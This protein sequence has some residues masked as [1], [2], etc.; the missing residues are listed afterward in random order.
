MAIGAMQAL[1]THGI[2]IP[3]DVI[4][5]GFDGIEETQAISPSLT[6]VRAPWHE[7]GSQGV[8]LVLLRLSGEPVPE[9]IHLQTE[10][11]LRQ[12]CGCLPS[13]LSSSRP[14]TAVVV[15]PEPSRSSRPSAHVSPQ[16]DALLAEMRRAVAATESA[17]GL[18]LDWA[19]RLLGAFLADAR[20][21][22][23]TGFLSQLEA[24]LSGVASGA[25]V[26]EWQGVL[27]AM[28]R[29]LLPL[30]DSPDLVLRAQD[31]WQKGLALVGDM[32]HRRQLYQR[33]VAVQQTDRLNQIIQ[34]MS[35]TY[36]VERLVDLLVHELPGLGIQ[37]CYLSLYEGEGVPPEFS[38]LILA[39]QGNNRL[40]LGSQA[41][42]FPTRQLVPLELL[43]GERQVAFDVEALYF[44]EDQ[45]GFVMF[46]LG[47]RDGEVYTALRGH[48]S[49]ALSNA[50]LYRRALQAREEA[51]HAEARAVKA[52]QL[53]TR[54]LANV[55]HEL[56]T[57]L[58]I[59]VG[60]SQTAM[61]A[62]NPY[63]VDLPQKLIQDLG[64][65]FEGGQHLIRLTNDLLDI[66]RAE[67]G[68]LD[69][70]IEPVS[71]RPLL[72]EMFHSIADTASP[73]QANIDWQLELPPHLPLI[74]ADPIRLRQIL[75]NLLSNARKFT[76]S[77]QI[78]LGA[79]VDIPHLHVWI[80]DTGIGIPVELQ[81]HIFEPFITADQ[82]GQRREG[83]GLGLSITRHLVALHGGSLTLES[84]PGQGSTFHVY[85]PL[86]GLSSPATRLSG[87]AGSQPVLLWLSAASGP[88]PAIAQLC[89]SLGLRLYRI[90]AGDDLDS[91][92]QEV[93]PAGLA[94][95]M[96]HARPGDWLVI[97]NLRSHPRICQ[98]PFLL[99]SQDPCGSPE[100]K[101]NVV[102]VLLK[103]VGKRTLLDVIASLQPA[104]P[105][106]SILVV[107]DDPQA[108]EHYRALIAE[109]L[110]DYAVRTAEGG[111]AALGI[112][113]DEIPDL[114][115]LDLMM[116]D[117][118]GFA[119]LEHLRRS[120]RTCS[121][122]VIVLS[123]RVLSYEDVKRL[124]YPR[125]AYQT[126]DVLLAEET[127]AEL[128]KALSSA[129]S[130]AQPT[131]ILVKRTLAYLHQN[132]SRILLLKE[133]ADA[134]GVSKSYL[135]R[136]FHSE[137]GISVWEYL[138]R[139]RVLKARELLA[140]TDESITDIAARVGFEDVGYF[141]RVFRRWA[142]HSPRA[143]RQQS[144]SR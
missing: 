80:K 119:V 79:Q 93:S 14:S 45:I 44:R 136:I 97:Q 76:D 17:R 85:L 102:N 51:L 2:R 26:I 82:P 65:I 104:A 4:V 25:E 62:P 10:L 6:T 123:G 72:E 12:S 1:R 132:Y 116:P 41:P 117:V 52:D 144:R 142:G 143:F 27:V 88:S 50:E 57:P 8:D 37:S 113:A 58:N 70:W 95:D 130:L 40:P 77:G 120:P 23:A 89:Q 64:H 78:V 68:E 7:M 86:P 48:L 103:P 56:R 87:G 53:K 38:R 96:A 36:D 137:V 63:G 61:A 46:E 60:F 32:A 114:V 30:L 124:D 111:S 126:K 19:E 138:S 135:S 109:T 49:S 67:I 31:L 129:E 5:T 128:Q 33:L 131:S 55:S 81:E 71:P 134:I 35:T 15:V 108:L 110:P 100:A 139:Y 127:L 66:S 59:I 105:S 112:L 107:D 94:W 28:Q 13:P 43:S 141:G 9:Q 73:A 84:H 20:S 54:L 101:P 133:I 140:L 98:L 106:G 125:V 39:C 99:F 22:T 3:E 90:K 91:L 47:P 34:T 29:R 24:I 18:A 92:L 69:L 16:E 75:L 74:Y 122:P 83:I 11:A 121:V 115:I 21:D 118:D 42:R